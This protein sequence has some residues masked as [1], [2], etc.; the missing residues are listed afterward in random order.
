MA[1]KKE[2]EVNNTGIMADYL[3]IKNFGMD[4][5]G[6]VIMVQVELF[7]SELARSSGKN[8]LSMLTFQVPLSAIVAADS[9]VL[10][11]LYTELKKDDQLIGAIDV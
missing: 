9:D 4:K 10:T 11:H 1:L 5:D 3:R 7:L 2:F 8:A 6:D